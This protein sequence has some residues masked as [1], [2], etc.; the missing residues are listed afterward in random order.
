MYFFL[1]LVPSVPNAMQSQGQPPRIVFPSRQEPIGKCPRTGRPHCLP[2]RQLA[3][4][5]ALFH[6]L[7]N[8]RPGRRVLSY[9]SPRNFNRLVSKLL[10]PFVTN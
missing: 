9:A 8:E 10:S 2:Q 1:S 4:S 7:A 6:F 5:P 3:E